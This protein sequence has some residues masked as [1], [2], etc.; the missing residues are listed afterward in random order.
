MPVG[1]EFNF[2]M[3]NDFDETFGKSIGEI[4][5]K[6]VAFNRRIRDEALGYITTAMGL[7]A[8]LAWNDA[9]KAF[10]E[11][12]FP[13]S[14]NTLL[15]KFLYAALITVFAVFVAKSFIGKDADEE[16]K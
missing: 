15:A 12:F 7:V 2:W 10:I 13:V 16:K 9:V 4:K 6:S 11:H 8:G 14:K 3:M 1:H 5:E